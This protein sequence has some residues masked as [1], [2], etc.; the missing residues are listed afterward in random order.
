MMIWSQSWFES[1]PFL[2]GA[3]SQL[4]L[5]LDRVVGL[6]QNSEELQESRPK[7]SSFRGEDSRP[8]CLQPAMKPPSSA[9]LL[10]R[11]HP[12]TPRKH[13]FRADAL[14]ARKPDLLR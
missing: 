4:A 2:Q 14:K 12:A 1:I 13:L 3:T 7:R 9:T 6:T 11:G 8:P 10:K 5:I